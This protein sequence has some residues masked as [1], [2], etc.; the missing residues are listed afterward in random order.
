[1]SRKPLVQGGASRERSRK[2][3]T[4]N[5]TTPQSPYAELEGE[6]FPLTDSMDVTHNPLSW[7]FEY[8]ISTLCILSNTLVNLEFWRI[9]Y[10]AEASYL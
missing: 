6:V 9:V 10:C 3:F 2:H 7:T 1:M 5:P 8:C 4:D